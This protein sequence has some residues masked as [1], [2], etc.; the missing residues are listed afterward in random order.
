M[1]VYL[2]KAVIAPKE[3]RKNKQKFFY[4]A[5]KG[6]VEAVKEVEKVISVDEEIVEVIEIS[7]ECYV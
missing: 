4:I 2:Y 6:L 3:D 5:K 1:K 7:E